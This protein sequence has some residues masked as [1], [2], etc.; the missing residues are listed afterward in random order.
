MTENRGLKG[1]SKA[2]VHIWIRQPSHTGT[3]NAQACIGSRQ[4]YKEEKNG[5][6]QGASCGVLAYT[7]F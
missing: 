1:A 3:E 4:E 5:P 2:I 6:N 7:S